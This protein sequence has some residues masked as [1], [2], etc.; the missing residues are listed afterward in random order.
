MH[1][2]RKQ[3]TQS[4][5][6]TEL[7]FSIDLDRNGFESPSLVKTQF[8]P[9]ELEALTGIT[10]ACVV[11]VLWRMYKT[12]QASNRTPGYSHWGW[13]VGHRW[14]IS[15]PPRKI[16]KDGVTYEEIVPDADQLEVSFWGATRIDA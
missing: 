4:A 7:A 16:V 9:M 13:H 3:N 10:S 6:K 2:L 14:Y 11:Y 12:A 8:K 5:E 15:R 1:L